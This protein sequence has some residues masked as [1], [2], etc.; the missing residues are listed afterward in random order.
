VTQP[1][2][3][4]LVRRSPLVLVVR[5]DGSTLLK[6]S[7]D[8]LDVSNVMMFVKNVMLPVLPDVPSVRLELQQIQPVFP[9]S[10]MLE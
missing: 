6:L 9:H 8:K 2:L 4:V 1:V 3:H 5:R 7:T 10:T